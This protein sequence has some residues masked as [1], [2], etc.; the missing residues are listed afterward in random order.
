[1]RYRPPANDITFNRFDA[2]GVDQLQAREK[3][4]DATPKHLM[5]AEGAGNRQSLE[6]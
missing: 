1:M 3:Y 2:S 4:A 5:S 6:G